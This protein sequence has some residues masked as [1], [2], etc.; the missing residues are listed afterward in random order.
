[1]LSNLTNGIPYYVVVRATNT[2]SLTSQSAEVSAVPTFI[3]GL[4]SPGFIDSLRVN[5]SGNDLVLTWTPVTTDIYGKPLGGVT[6]QVFRGTT[7]GFDPSL[8][9]P[10]A[11]NLSSATFTDP[12]AALAGTGYYYLVRARD[13]QGNVGG[14]GHQ[15]PNGIDLLT[16]SKSATPGNVLLS[17]PA[18][19][20][21]FD[22]RP[23]RIR[24]YRI[25]ARG[26]PFTRA[27]IRNGTVGPPLMTTT[28]TQVELTPPAG[29]QHY[30]VLVVDER[31]NLS[32]F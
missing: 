2:S 12:G 5:R 13:G 9:P 32:S 6:Y 18:V 29:G 20:T 30:S 23:S 11:N 1:V 31:G 15:L 28:G 24:E 7:A 17:W 3:R 16:L 25:Y 22:G 10:L 4:K 14:L 26:T 27:D 19:T 21:D 8:G